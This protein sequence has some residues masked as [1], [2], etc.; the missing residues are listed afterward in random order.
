MTSYGS[1]CKSFSCQPRQNVRKTF[2]DIDR[3][4][5]RLQ[6]VLIENKDFEKLIEQYDREGAFFYCDPP[7]WSTV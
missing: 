6:N 2:Q 4:N 3:C 5:R 7:Y 1:G